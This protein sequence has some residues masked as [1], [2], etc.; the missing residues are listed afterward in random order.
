[1]RPACLH[2]WET[3][4][5]RL[6]EHFDVPRAAVVRRVLA[7]VTL[8]MCPANWH[9]RV[10]EGRAAQRS[11]VQRDIDGG[12]QRLSPCASYVDNLASTP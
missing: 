10:A 6:A 2:P 3:T 12:G 9:L 1:V 8:D 11:P 5:Q 4:L 7:G